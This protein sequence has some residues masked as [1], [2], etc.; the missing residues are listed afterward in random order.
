MPDISGSKPHRQA[1]ISLVSMRKG[2]QVIT[3]VVL[4]KTNEFTSPG[5]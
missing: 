3:S 5:T 4:V 2:S 1:R